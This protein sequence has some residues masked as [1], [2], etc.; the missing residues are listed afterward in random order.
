MLETAV[1]RNRRDGR[2]HFL[3]AMIHLYRF[4]QRVT[5]FDDVSAEARAELAAANVAFAAA[6]PLLWDDASGYAAT[7]A[8]RASPRR[9]STCRAWSKTTPRCARRGSPTSSAPCR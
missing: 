7:H 9:R 8:F 5:R 6:L 1:R 4:G 3:L 2:S